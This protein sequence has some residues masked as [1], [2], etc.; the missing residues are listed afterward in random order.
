MYLNC[1][2]SSVESHVHLACTH[3]SCSFQEVFRPY[4]SLSCSTSVS[5]HETRHL[6]RC[7]LAAVSRHDQNIVGLIPQILLSHVSGLPLVA[8]LTLLCMLILHAVVTF[9]HR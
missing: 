7:C 2:A 1:P 9:L 4:Y 5:L 3:K 8:I 6:A